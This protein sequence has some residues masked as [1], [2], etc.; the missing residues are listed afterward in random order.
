MDIFFVNVR[1]REYVLGL[2]ASRYRAEVVAGAVKHLPRPILGGQRLDGETDG[3]AS[4]EH[5]PGQG[6]NF[7]EDIHRG[8]WEVGLAGFQA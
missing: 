3:G 8:S 5:Q 7:C 4:N 1:D 2:G 6:S